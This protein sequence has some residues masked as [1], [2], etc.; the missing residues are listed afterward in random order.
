MYSRVKWPKGPHGP[1]CLKFVE[2]L[3]LGWAGQN[4]VQMCSSLTECL[5]T[6]GWQGQSQMGTNTYDQ[7]RSR[8]L[9]KYRSKY[10]RNTEISGEETTIWDQVWRNTEARRQWPLLLKLPNPLSPPTSLVTSASHLE[11]DLKPLDFREK[12]PRKKWSTIDCERGLY[13]IHV[14]WSFLACDCHHC[15]HKTNLRALGSAWPFGPLDPRTRC[16]PADSRGHSA[17]IQVG[18]C[19]VYRLRSSECY[20]QTDVIRPRPLNLLICAFCC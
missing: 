12:Y 20:R 5:P 2:I 13:G 19:N 6:L 17:R 7:T 18:S 14:H 4:E 1:W 9:Q 8:D 3:I 10:K 11:L 16:A 15:F